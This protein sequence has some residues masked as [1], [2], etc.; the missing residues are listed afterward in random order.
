MNQEERKQPVL[1]SRDEL[2]RQVW[3]TPMIRLGEQYGITGNGLKKICERLKIPYPPL[4]YWAKLQAGKAVNQTPL[5][6]ADAKTPREVTITPTLSATHVPTLPTIAP[7]VAEKLQT[8]LA[9]S[10]T[11]TVPKTL[12]GPHPSIA[13]WITEHE[14]RIAADKRDRSRWGSGFHTKPFTELERR[15][16]R[17][18]DTLYKELEKR[19]FKIR[20][21]APYS[22]SIEINSEK[23]EIALR[24]RIRQVRRPLNDEEKAS[25]FHTNQQWR[26]EKLPTGELIFAL[27]TYLGAGLT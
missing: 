26:Q 1:V 27:K 25:I 9:A 19:G 2:H 4:G 22:V 5:P 17:I 21:P 23:I 12:R 13:A 16:Q 6:D 3:Q 18:L 20:G 7:E 14:R 15:Q 24:E 11:I 8:A 10:S